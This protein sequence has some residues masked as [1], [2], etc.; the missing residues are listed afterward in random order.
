MGKML[1]FMGIFLFLI[2]IIVTARP[3]IPWIS[4]LS[5]DF[6]IQREPLSLYCP[7]TPTLSPMGRGR[8]LGLILE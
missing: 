8:N 1:L 6:H 2:G 4:K 5:G 7:L 3:K